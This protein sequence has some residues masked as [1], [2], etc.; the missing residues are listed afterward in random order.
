[1]LNYPTLIE[2]CGQDHL[3]DYPSCLYR[4]EYRQRCTLAQDELQMDW[5]PLF[6]SGTSEELEAHFTPEGA[7]SFLWSRRRPRQLYRLD[8]EGETPRRLVDQMLR[9]ARF[10]PDGRAIAFLAPDTDRGA[11]WDWGLWMSDA[12]G[13]NVRRIPTPGVP[14]RHLDFSPDGKWLWL[15]L[16]SYR[17]PLLRGLYR[18]ELATGQLTRESNGDFQEFCVSPDG[19]SLLFLGGRGEQCLGLF[20]T[21]TGREKVLRWISQESLGMGESDL[22]GPHFS[23][24]GGRLFYSVHHYGED[25]SLSQLCATLPDGAATRVMW[26]EE[27]PARLVVP[28]CLPPAPRELEL[29]GAGRMSRKLP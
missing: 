12:D 6:V 5:D 22:V 14:V 19:R 27:A 8:R 24:D 21:A 23:P 3:H 25:W 17:E 7:V 11:T 18:Y 10:S 29:V 26:E 4:A 20:D 15:S 9:L 1:M 16:W 2:V 28:R 13:G